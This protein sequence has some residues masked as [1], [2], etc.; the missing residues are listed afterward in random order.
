MTSLSDDTDK[1]F[2]QVRNVISYKYSM[3]IQDQKIDSKRG[4]NICKAKH[5]KSPVRPQAL[6]KFQSRELP[7]C[8]QLHVRMENAQKKK[9]ETNNIT[10]DKIN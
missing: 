4:W 1:N 2:G 9:K 8:L 7:L 5:Y 10:S 3:K 6:P